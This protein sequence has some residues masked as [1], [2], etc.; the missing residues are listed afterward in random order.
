M[1]STAVEI[2]GYIAG[3]YTI[4][5]G[6]SDVAFTVRDP[7]GGTRAGFS[8]TT[9]LNHTER[10]LQ[11]EQEDVSRFP[12]GPGPTACEPAKAPGP[13]RASRSGGNPRP[14]PSR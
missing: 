9:E 1:S 10:V 6:H 14:G 4:D 11:L 13:R 8:A 2:S 7:Y 12:S 5:P 3:T